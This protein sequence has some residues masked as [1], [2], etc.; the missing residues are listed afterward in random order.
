LSGREF[1]IEAEV[2]NSNPYLGEQIIYTFRLYQATNF[3]G[4]PDYN[5]PSFTDFWSSEILVQPHFDAEADGNQYLVTE[6][7][8]ALFPANLGSI[9]IEPATLVIPGGVF[10]PDIK[11]ETNPVQVEVKPLPDG[12]P[13]DFSGAVGQYEIEASLSESVVKVNEPVTLRIEIGGTGNI[14]T[15]T[16]P[17][18]PELTNWRVF[19]SQTSTTTENNE[20]KVRGKRTYE[21]LVVPSRP[22]EQTFPAINFS[23]FDPQVAAYQTVSSEPIPL[24]V[25]PDDSAQTPPLIVD[26]DDNDRL[27]VE[28]IGADIRHIKPVPSSLTSVSQ[29][30]PLIWTIFACFWMMPLLIVGGVFVWHRRYRRLQEDTTY[31]RDQ[32]ARRVAL[33]ILNQARQAGDNPANAAGRAIL[34]YL[35][36]KLN[37]PTVGLT[38]NRLINLLRDHQLDPALINRVRTLLDQ[39]DIGRFAPVSESAGH[40]M[41]DDAQQLVNDI[42]KSLGKKR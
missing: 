41:L 25:L 7:R 32:R 26:T 5:P 42:E 24:T 16:E 17:E 29:W 38:T 9:T 20:D 18:L 37:K 35:S 40:S 22:G 11:L 13:D 1:W 23:Y 33:Q 34:G 39:I 12:A 3:F 8:T 27:P 6:I 31:A 28:L 36:D 14:Q 2:D 30:S 19:E 15:I 21:R 10:N 4:Q